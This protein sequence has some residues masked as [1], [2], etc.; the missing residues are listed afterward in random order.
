MVGG[1]VNQ[2]YCERCEKNNE[3]ISGQCGG[4]RSE[5]FKIN[6][7]ID[8]A[9]EK[10]IHVVDQV[11]SGHSVRTCQKQRWFQQTKV[12]RTESSDDGE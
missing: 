7:D 2:N 9:L 12:V 11:S 6:G 4:R 10:R 8:E 1:K 3:G 5:V